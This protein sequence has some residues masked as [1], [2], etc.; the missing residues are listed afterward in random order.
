MAIGEQYLAQ[1]RQAEARFNAIS[2]RIIGLTPWGAFYPLMKAGADIGE[3][4]I[5]RKVCTYKGRIVEVAKSEHG[6]WVQSFIRPAHEHAGKAFSQGDWWRGIIGLS[7]H[8]WI[9]NIIEQQN[10]VCSQITPNEFLMAFHKTYQTQQSERQAGVVAE[11]GALA[12]IVV[13]IVVLIGIYLRF[14]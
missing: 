5:P 2:E 4:M 10:A 7:G 6:K 12:L 1:E 3:G 14:K 8:G 9:P 11:M 13:V